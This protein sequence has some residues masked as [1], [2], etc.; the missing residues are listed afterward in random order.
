LATPG[1]FLRDTAGGAPLPLGNGGALALS[2]DTHLFVQTSSSVPAH[3]VRFDL[4]TG[5]RTPWR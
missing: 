4:G 2:P 3:I 5:R 1:F